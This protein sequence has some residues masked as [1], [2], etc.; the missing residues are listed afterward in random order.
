MPVLTTTRVRSITTLG[1]GPWRSR[2]SPTPSKR[3]QI[4][5]TLIG[6]GASL[7]IDKININYLSEITI[8]PCN[9]IRMRQGLPKA[10]ATRSESWDSLLM[11]TMHMP[12]LARLITH[13]VRT[14]QFRSLHILQIL[15][16]RITNLVISN[17]LLQNTTRRSKSPQRTLNI[18]ECEGLHI[19]N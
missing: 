17:W 7:T 3:T 1:I 9:S 18:I 2:S 6:I 5:L 14:H 12:R 4:T 11:L 8:K 19:G 10:R 16:L 13:I 15:D